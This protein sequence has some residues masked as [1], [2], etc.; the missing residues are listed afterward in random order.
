MNSAQLWDRCRRYL[1]RAEGR[2]HQPERDARWA[3]I[4]CARPGLHRIA[5]APE[6]PG[7]NPDLTPILG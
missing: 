3:T 5:I 1:C 2:A 4:G 6:H 7:R